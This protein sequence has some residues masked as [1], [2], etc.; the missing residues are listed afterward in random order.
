M[1]FISYF[2]LYLG[3]EN[4]PRRPRSPAIHQVFLDYSRWHVPP[5]QT[6]ST[7]LSPFFGILDG[8]GNFPQIQAHRQQMVT[9]EK[10]RA[11]R[12]SL[13]VTWEHFLF[14]PGL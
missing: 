5:A 3:P 1:P 4:F 12:L 9:E 8:V 2:S 14:E 11:D 7:A 13:V 6:T 10:E